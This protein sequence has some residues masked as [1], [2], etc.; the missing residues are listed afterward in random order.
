MDYVY[1]AG[2]S[3]YRNAR[4]VLEV[5]EDFG[6]V[7]VFPDAPMT[8]DDLGGLVK[9]IETDVF[10]KARIDLNN[11]CRVVLEQDG[12][13]YDVELSEDKPRIVGLKQRV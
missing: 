9:Y 7:T 13:S 1:T 5:G 4:V 2:E 3:D 12:K 6:T 8:E 10:K 11:D